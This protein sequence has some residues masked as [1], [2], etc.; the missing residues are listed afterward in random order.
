MFWILFISG[1][2]AMIV[3]I[4]LLCFSPKGK[5]VHPDVT[6]ITFMMGI[7]A[8]AI[9]V[10]CSFFTAQG[11][12]NIMALRIQTIGGNYLIVDNSGGKTLRHWIL[13]KSYL[14][15]SDQSGGWMFYSNEEGKRYGPY[16]VSGDAF[17]YHITEPLDT[18]LLNY[19]KRFNIPEDLKPVKA[20]FKK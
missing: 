14:G 8:G 3:F 13:I 19:K 12:L 9:L 20:E 10:T 18:F 1:L 4:A 5:Y 6:M 7:I 11:R 17:T 16:H 2:A 15:A